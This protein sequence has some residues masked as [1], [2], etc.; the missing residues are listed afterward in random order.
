MVTVLWRSD[1][2]WSPSTF[3]HRARSGPVAGAANIASPHWATSWFDTTRLFQFPQ[4]PQ[5]PLL[6]TLQ[7][8][9]IDW[10][11][12]CGFGLLPSLRASC[13]ALGDRNVQTD[14]SSEP[15]VKR[16]ARIRICR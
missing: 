10:I 3:P 11:Q 4:H 6:V 1:R 12:T 15:S 16:W 9:K 8:A 14:A 2:A 5:L 7:R 13:Q